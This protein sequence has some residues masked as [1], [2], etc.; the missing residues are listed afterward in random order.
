[1]VPQMKDIQELRHLSK[2]QC[3]Q[4]SIECQKELMKNWRYWIGLYLSLSLA[5][6]GLHIGF[7]FGWLVESL[8]APWSCADWLGVLVSLAVASGISFL[9]IAIHARMVF[10]VSK[11]LWIECTRRKGWTAMR[12]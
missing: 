1:M 6:I 7:R 2:W 8:M 12:S 11:P 4:I 10:D 9:G 3:F 5:L